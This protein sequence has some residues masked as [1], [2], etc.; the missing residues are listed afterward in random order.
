MHC[1]VPICTINPKFVANLLRCNYGILTWYLNSFYIFH[2]QKAPSSLPPACPSAQR[3]IVKCVCKLFS[4]L[5]GNR[6]YAYTTCFYNVKV[7]TDYRIYYENLYEKFKI[8]SRAVAFC[9]IKIQQQNNS[10]YSHLI[11]SNSDTYK[12]SIHNRYFVQ[13]KP[14]LLPYSFPQILPQALIM[15]QHL[16]KLLPRRLP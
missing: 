5:I 14:R 10:T 4:Y 6:I 16:I 1:C 12:P 8:T 11:F 13:I 15:R 3:E 7:Y 2:S 9:F